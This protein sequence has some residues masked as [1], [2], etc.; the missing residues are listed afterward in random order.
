[1]FTNFHKG[2]PIA[3]NPANVTYILAVADHTDI[4][5]AAAT[6]EDEAYISVNEPLD[7]VVRILN[8]AMEDRH[9]NLD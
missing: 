5:F 7:D 2:K 1:M 9:G 3:V 8:E 6:A 4:Q